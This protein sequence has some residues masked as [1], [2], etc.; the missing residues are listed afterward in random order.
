LKGGG[1]GLNSEMNNVE[2][3]KQ[4][5][6]AVARIEQNM[7]NMSEQIKEI[8][9]VTQL[10][11][12]TDQSVKSAHNR[13]DDLKQDLKDGLAEK[14]KDIGKL[15]DHN[16]WLWRSIAVGMIAYVYEFIFK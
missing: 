13:I 14:E 7:S 4:L 3:T 5:L 2:E 11:L 15:E 12:Q 6:V 16:K 1:K 8:N 10:T 9:K